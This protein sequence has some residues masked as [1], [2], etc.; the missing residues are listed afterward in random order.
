MQEISREYHSHNLLEEIRFSNICLCTQ[1]I[2]KGCHSNKPLEVIRSSDRCPH[3]QEIKVSSFHIRNNPRWDR[4][5]RLLG[6]RPHIW[7]PLHLLGLQRLD[8]LWCQDHNHES[9]W[10]HQPVPVIKTVLMIFGFNN[11]FP[12]HHSNHSPTGA[13][14]NSS[15]NL[16]P[17]SYSRLGY[18]LH[19]CQEANWYT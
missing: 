4:R 7:G 12:S 2:N 15:L 13:L 19:V 14:N 8:G 18:F 9:L 17:R 3:M 11:N 10:S 5:Y 6:H 1:G 16:E